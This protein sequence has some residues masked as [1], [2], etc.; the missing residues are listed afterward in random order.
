[1]VQIMA[2]N[3]EN[4]E[5]K[6]IDL[7]SVTSPT[8]FTILTQP[9][10]ALQHICNIKLATNCICDFFSRPIIWLPATNNMMGPS[11]GLRIWMGNSKQCLLKEK[12]CTAV[13]IWG[14]VSDAP[15]APLQFRQPGECWYCQWSR[16]KERISLMRIDGWLR[17][18]C[19]VVRRRRHSWKEKN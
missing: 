11:E 7:K 5:D 15:P 18:Q 9:L 2:L 1:M 8:R 4:S 13:K 17:R 10:F 12:N 14:R 19:S 6:K 16:L 3:Y